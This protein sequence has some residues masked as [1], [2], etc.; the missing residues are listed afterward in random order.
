MKKS[1]VYIYSNKEYPV[2]VTYKMKKSISYRLKDGVF[3]VSAPY[4]VTQKRIK[5]GLDK[6]AKKLIERDNLNKSIEND[7]RIFLFG[8]EVKIEGDVATFSSG[9]K[10]TF[11]S[12]EDLINKLIWIYSDYMI[13]RTRYY[14][15]LMSIVP[16]YKVKIKKMKSRF[17]SNSKQT[18]TISYANHL[19]SYS[20]DILDSLIVHELAHHFFFDHSKNFYSVV[21][22]YCPNYKKDNVKLKKRIFK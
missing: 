20:R 16:S 14:E 2:E 10:M 11:V 22:K 13:E 17:G 19:Y 21:Y 18:H 3:F 4:M 5:E 8:D 6:F 12:R 15:S 9:E 7:K 1:F